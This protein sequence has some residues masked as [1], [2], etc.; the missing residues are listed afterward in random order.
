MFVYTRVEKL[1]KEIESSRDLFEY[2]RTCNHKDNAAIVRI[3]GDEGYFD[4]VAAIN[5]QMQRAANG[6]T[7]TGGGVNV[8]NVVS[9]YADGGGWRFVL[10]AAVV[11]VQ[12][13][14]MPQRPMLVPG[15]G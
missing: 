7:L 15:R 6:A 11:N 10:G 2:L 1:D 5:D 14:Q 13:P 8:W 4:L 9:S 3:E 12:Q